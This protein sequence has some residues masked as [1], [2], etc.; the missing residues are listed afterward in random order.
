MSL[1]DRLERKFGWF[2]LPNLTLYIIIGQ[3]GVLLGYLMGRVNLGFFV[4]WAQLVLHGQWWRIFTFVLMPPPPDMF[5]GYIGVA[6]AWYMFYL[7]GSTLEGYWGAFRYN[8]FLLVGYALTVGVAFF[9]P[10]YPATNLFLAGSVFLAFA[11]LNPDF[12]I[13][14]LFILPVR[15]KWIALVTWIWYAYLAVTGGMMTRL[16]LAAAVGNYLL[17]FAGD[18][19]RSLRQGRRS[20]ARRAQAVV[21]T[22][23][24]RH[25]CHVCGKTDISH[26]D[27][28]FR[29]CSKCAGD[30]CYCP[31]HIHNHAH[32]VAPENQT[33]Q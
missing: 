11:R 6:F 13:L 16:M 17:F 7:F 5:F 1:L 12:S 20:M 23:Q 31:E 24:P 33:G 4:L 27:L 22:R 15:I 25:V 30:Q 28:D 18:I 3:V 2:A 9:A 10:Q 32:V 19:I 26:P 14:L 21:E 8:L 29:Y